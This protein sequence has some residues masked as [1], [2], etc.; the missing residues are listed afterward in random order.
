MSAGMALELFTP[1][2]FAPVQGVVVAADNNVAGPAHPD[3]VLVGVEQDHRVAQDVDSVRVLEQVGALLVVVLAKA[4][5]DAIDLLSLSR[6]PEA[7]QV[8]PDGHVEGQPCMC[9]ATSSKFA[10]TALPCQ[11][12]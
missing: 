12:E 4:L 11:T 2:S 10:N 1:K 9:S 6:Q 5:H 7:L 8:Q 3:I